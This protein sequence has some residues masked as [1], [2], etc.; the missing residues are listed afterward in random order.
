LA[1]C[2]GSKTGAPLFRARDTRARLLVAACAAVFFVFSLLLS[3]SA[4]DCGWF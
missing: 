3:L 1:H 2:L 4:S